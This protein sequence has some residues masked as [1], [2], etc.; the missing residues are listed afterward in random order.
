MAT[1]NQEASD[2]RGRKM[3]DAL[4]SLFKWAMRHRRSAMKAN[5]VIGTFRP[6]PPP[7]RDRVLSDDEIASLWTACDEAVEPFGRIIR[8]L[9]LTGC[10]LNEIAKLEWKELNEEFST[11]ALPGRRTKNS[12]PLVVMLPPLAREIIKGVKRVEDC[13]YVFTITGKTPPSGW[14]KVKTRLDEVM[15][16]AAKKDKTTLAPWR[17]H[18]LRRTAA[19]GMAELGIAP[20]IVEAALNHVSGARAG[21]AGTYNRAQYV[22][23]KRAALERWAAHVEGIV[24]DRQPKV[25]ALR[26]P[27]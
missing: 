20:H 9:L 23:E 22:E 24:T 17:L 2:N 18:D 10:R 6:G 12:L 13:P 16:E 8:L 27:R 25:V 26:Q 5:P 21:V 14:S 1:K 7:P 19:T 3:G 11:I 4:G 15:V